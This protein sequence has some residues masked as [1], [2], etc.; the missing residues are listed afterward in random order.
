M[1]GVEG[2]VLWTD[3]GRS[4]NKIII[5]ARQSVRSENRATF[6]SEKSNGEING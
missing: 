5:R 1:A 4:L 3:G 2:R 6:L